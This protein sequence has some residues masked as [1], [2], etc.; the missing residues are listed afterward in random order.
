MALE[1]GE[2]SIE[3][4]RVPGCLGAVLA[5]GGSRRMDGRSKA[6][7]DLAG[8]TML[9]HVID[10][11]RPQA[12]S[13]VLSL[14]RHREEYG[15]FGLEQ[16]PDLQPDSGPLG[17]LASVL[18]HAAGAWEW[19]LL[20][21]CDAPFVPRDLG[22]RLY[23][24]AARAQDTVAVVRYGSRLQP[25]FSIWHASLLDDVRQAVMQRGMAGFRQFLSERDHCILDWPEAD[26][27]P[28]FN[29]ND[30]AALQQARR[31]ASM[32]EEKHT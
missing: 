28:F 8:R 16:V 21:P 6:L 17:G 12:A 3:A 30:S 10:R 25:V 11:L 13:L 7:L 23:D 18:A 26:E 19:V 1:T 22:R 31:R 2:F 5:G 29:V 15:E 24:A 27:N 9:Q 20:A 32:H 14:D 4:R